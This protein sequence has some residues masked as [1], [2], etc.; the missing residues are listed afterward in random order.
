MPRH[1]VPGVRAARQ[2]TVALDD[3]VTGV[4][5]LITSEPGCSCIKESPL[6]RDVL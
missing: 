6:D 5:C 1:K 2:V 3:E 4:G